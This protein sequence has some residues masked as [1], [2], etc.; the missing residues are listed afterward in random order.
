[1]RDS[2]GKKRYENNEFLCFYSLDYIPEI[3]I[4]APYESMSNHQ[5]RKEGKIVKKRRYYNRRIWRERNR[6]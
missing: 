5:M 6:I 3:D 4:L 1:M 2:F